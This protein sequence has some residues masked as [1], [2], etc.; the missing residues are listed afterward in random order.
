MLTIKEELSKV[1][2]GCSSE[3][4]NLTV[5]PLLARNAPTAKPDYMLLEDGIAEGKVRITELNAGG[6]V[7]ELRV[8]NAADIPVLL[9][10]GEELVGAKQNRVLNLTVLVAAKQMTVIPVSCV[11]AGRWSMAN[12]DLRPANHFM[13]ARARGDRLSQVT[14]SMRATS[15]RRSDQAAI[16]EEI[17]GKSARLGVASPTQSM[18]HVFNRH[19]TA[20][21]EFLRRFAWL[22]G[23]RGA[24]FAIRGQFVGLDLFDH[25]E[26]MRRFFGKLIRSYALDALDG[27]AVSAGLL[28]LESLPAFLDKIGD[29]AVYC[30]DAIGIGKD[31]RFNTPELCGAGLW[32]QEHYLHLCAFV[33][34]KRKVD[35]GFWTRLSRPS[36]RRAF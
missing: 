20:L 27:T 31:L 29:A 11:E 33:K 21:E 8:E 30:E 28:P 26:T 36:Q 23:Q 22:D 5:F 17:A 7:P 9:V 10:D 6:S 35:S 13:Y 32:A 34:P 18:S 4:L 19:A 1:E 14:Q 12:P 24:A 16:W 15:S 25:P 2:M 3:F